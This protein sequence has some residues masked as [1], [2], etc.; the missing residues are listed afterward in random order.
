VTE[1]TSAEARRRALE[2]RFDI[3]GSLADYA[4]S[5]SALQLEVAKQYPDIHLGTGYQWDQG[6]SKWQLGVT[7]EVPVLNRNEG[8]IAEAQERRAEAAARFEALQAKVLGDVNRA[9]E[10]FRATE[11]SL[12]NLHT[13]AEAQARQRETVQAEL[14]AGAADRLDLLNA[15]VELAA[16]ELVRLEAEIK[17]KQ[18]L[19]SLED[20][21]QR[22]I[23]FSGA[24][25]RSA[26]LHA[27]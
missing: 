3:L 27:N 13:L 8:P 1:L 15:Q 6:E 19:A 20:A 24:V 7:A 23:E 14:N 2:S 5:Q 4:A 10:T 12:T 21:I 17:R 18:A 11:K 22:P 9:M 16:T 25:F 26:R